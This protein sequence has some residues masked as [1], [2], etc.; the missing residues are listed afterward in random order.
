MTA[1]LLQ[2]IEAAIGERMFRFDSAASHPMLETALA[3]RH[4]GCVVFL[5]R[6]VQ[7][8]VELLGFLALF[9]AFAL[10]D[11][12]AFRII[13]EFYVRPAHRGQGVGSALLAAARDQGASRGG[14]CWR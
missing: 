2:E 4:C 5:V 11:N 7:H 9:E 3:R 1:E 8:G 14:I 12:G 6:G 10:Y 13:S